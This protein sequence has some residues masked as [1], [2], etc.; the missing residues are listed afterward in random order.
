M[1]ENSP[2]YCHQIADA[3]DNVKHLLPDGD[4]LHIMNMIGAERR[5]DLKLVSWRQRI[6]GGPANEFETICRPCSLGAQL[7][8]VP[9]L[10]HHGW[11]DSGWEELHTSISFHTGQSEY[12]VDTI[13]DVPF[14]HVITTS[15][16]VQEGELPTSGTDTESEANNDEDENSNMSSDTQSYIDSEDD[17]TLDDGVISHVDLEDDAATNDESEVEGVPRSDSADAEQWSFSIEPATVVEFRLRGAEEV[18]R[19]TRL[20]E[21]QNLTSQFNKFNQSIRLQGDNY[22]DKRFDSVCLEGETIVMSFAT[23]DRFTDM[24]MQDAHT[25]EATVGLWECLPECAKHPNIEVSVRPRHNVEDN[26]TAAAEDWEITVH[27]L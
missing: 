5:K 11:Y 22:T 18:P 9:A 17:V 15:G 16:P 27:P 3:I 21:L 19:A 20:V 13:V 1:S 6:E 2:S 14:H 10:L 24:D 25:G 23:L 7:E 26:G 12:I 4:Y 8:M